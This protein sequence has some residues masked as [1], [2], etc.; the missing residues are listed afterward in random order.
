[1]QCNSKEINSV[2]LPVVLNSSVSVDSYVMGFHVYQNIWRP[3]VGKRLT[4]QMEPKNVADKYTACIKKGEKIIG[5]FNDEGRNSKIR[6]N[7]ILFF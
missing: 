5:H 1:M 2:V 6:K 7:D 3:V 4:T